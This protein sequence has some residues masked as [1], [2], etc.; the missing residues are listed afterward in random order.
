MQMFSAIPSDT[1]GAGRLI[2]GHIIFGNVIIHLAKNVQAHTNLEITQVLILKQARN[3]CICII[4]L[5][6]VDARVVFDDD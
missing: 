2:D 5:H 3:V 6:R 1:R 4:V